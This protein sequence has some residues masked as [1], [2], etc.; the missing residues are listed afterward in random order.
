MSIEVDYSKYISRYKNLVED[1]ARDS[2]IRELNKAYAVYFGGIPVVD[3]EPESL[4]AR[5]RLVLES[6]C[7]TWIYM[8]NDKVILERVPPELEGR[9]SMKELAQIINGIYIEEE[10]CVVISWDNFKAFL[11]KKIERISGLMSI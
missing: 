9:L 11:D 6:R 5:I 10:D 7:L 8:V 4:Q 1:I 2:I 3:S